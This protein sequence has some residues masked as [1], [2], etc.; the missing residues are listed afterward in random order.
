MRKAET[1]EA[2]DSGVEAPLMDDFPLM[3]GTQL[4]FEA[5]MARFLVLRKFYRRSQ[6]ND[7]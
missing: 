2:E 1:A 6:L 4:S 5:G 7:E 3:A